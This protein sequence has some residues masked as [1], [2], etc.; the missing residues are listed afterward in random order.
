MQKT[1]RR[2]FGGEGVKTVKVMVE[3]QGPRVRNTETPVSSMYPPNLSMLAGFL[4]PLGDSIC[5]GNIESPAGSSFL[6]IGS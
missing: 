6:Q 1:N 4:G 3:I 5:P 2:V